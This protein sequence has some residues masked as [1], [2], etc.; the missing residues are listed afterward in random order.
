M[1]WGWWKVGR[2][3]PGGSGTVKWYQV[4]LAYWSLSFKEWLGV[5]CLFNRKNSIPKRNNYVFPLHVQVSLC[6]VTWLPV[7]GLMAF[8]C[9]RELSGAAS[10]TGWNSVAV[11]I[12][13]FHGN[14]L[15]NCL[16]GVFCFSFITGKKYL[17]KTTK[18]R[19][20]IYKM[21]FLDYDNFSLGRSEA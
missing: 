8:Q 6:K 21:F 12:S 10:K 14:Y 2:S 9:H 19:F 4:V 13:V 15:L 16:L 3:A 5:T 20:S 18:K 11:R 1:V 7:S 17:M